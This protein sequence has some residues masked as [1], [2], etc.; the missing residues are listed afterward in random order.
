MIS[1]CRYNADQCR[2]VARSPF[3]QTDRIGP[4]SATEWGSKYPMD[5]HT[6]GLKICRTL[7]IG[8]VGKSAVFVRER[9]V[10]ARERARIR[11]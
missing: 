1:L 3:E 5:S 10:F 2:I 4:D 7:C 8:Y 11:I 9:G 6:N